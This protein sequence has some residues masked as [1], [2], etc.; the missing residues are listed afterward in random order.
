MFKSFIKGIFKTTGSL[1]VLGIGMLIYDFV[2]TKEIFTEIKIK[3]EPEK[4]ELKETEELETE[5]LEELETEELETEEL[6]VEK[7]EFF[8][9][10]RIE[11]KDIGDVKKLFTF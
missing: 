11:S 7:L 4:I 3:L 5:E 2:S 6:E 8:S 9:V 10:D 1:F